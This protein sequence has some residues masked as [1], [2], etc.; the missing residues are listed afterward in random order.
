MVLTN[1]TKEKTLSKL[2]LVDVVWLIFSLPGTRVIKN[3]STEP[4]KKLP[5]N[6]GTLPLGDRNRIRLAVE[7]LNRNRK[8]VTY[9][10]G[11]L[12]RIEDAIE[13]YRSHAQNG[14]YLEGMKYR[15]G[16]IVR[17]RHSTA[18]IQRLIREL[19]IHIGHR[20]CQ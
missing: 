4:L 8:T 12:V 19:A 5:E 1:L 6:Y 14:V 17:V 7:K 16:Q 2:D 11:H 15:D 9:A 20:Y 18:L 13:F 3:C 10:G